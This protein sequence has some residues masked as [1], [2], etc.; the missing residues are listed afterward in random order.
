MAW[1]LAIDIGGTFTD[2][3]ALDE[4]SGRIHLLKVR[5]T[6][7]DPSTGFIE[8]VDEIRAAAKILPAEISGET[9]T[10]GTRTPNR[11][12]PK[13]NSPASWSGGTAPQGGGTWS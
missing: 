13:L 4:V 9:R 10:V 12:K 7:E 11:S 8:G 6:S 5:T 3:V 1:R 2:L